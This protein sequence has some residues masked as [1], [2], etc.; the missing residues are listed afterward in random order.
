[1]SEPSEEEMI[2]ETARRFAE[3]ELM[4]GAAE[5]D[6][7]SAFPLAEMKK[8]GEIGLLAICVDE[9]WGGSGS[10]Y[11]AMTMAVEEVSRADASIGVVMSTH[12]SLACMPIDKHGSEAQKERFLKPL[13]RGEKIGAVAITESQAGSNAADIR[14]RAVRKD[15]GYVLTGAKQMITA[16]A[17]A[18]IVLLLASTD[19][20]AG[21]RGITCFIVPTETPGFSV[22]RVEEKLGIKASGT[23]QLVLDGVELGEEH[24]LGGIGGGYRLMLSALSRSR[25]GIAAQAVG[26]AQAALD[27]SLAYARERSSFGKPIIEHQAVAFRLASMATEIEAARR[28]TYH[29]AELLDRGRPFQKESSMAKIFAAEMAERVC[30]QGLQVLGGYGYLCDYPLERL[31][32]D[33]RICQIYEGTSDIQRMVVSRILA[34]G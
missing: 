22:A 14:T 8:L 5:R 13:A 34:E 33:A 4:P 15:G 20:D 29:A 23:A 27:A 24:V 28:L 18:D 6:R 30:S 3:A 31:Y 10:T 9:A 16:G 17:F 11:K 26:I 25:L 2:A 7:N 19:P 1:M 32:R 21:P 12:H